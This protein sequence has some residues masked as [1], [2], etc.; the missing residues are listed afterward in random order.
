MATAKRTTIYDALLAQLRVNKAVTEYNEDLLKDYMALWD[1][2]SGLI[3]DIKK[4]GV[5]YQ[6]V[7]AAGVVMWKNN[8]S[9][10]ELVAVN[11]QMMCILE[12]LGLLPD[13]DGGMKGGSG[14]D[15]DDAD[16]L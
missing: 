3:K 13:N 1:T 15:A 10:K 5:T 11:K 7:S 4:R 2:K 6:D 14:G 8:P 16:A 9:V 12:K